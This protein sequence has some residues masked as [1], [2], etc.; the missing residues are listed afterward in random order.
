MAE[1]AKEAPAKK[2]G[3]LPLILILALVLGGGGFFGMKMR[4]G[5]S[6]KPKGPE[7]AA[8]I[9]VLPEIVAD[10]SDGAYVRTEVGVQL[11]KAFDPKKFEAAMPLV[12]QAANDT[13]RF[14]TRRDVRTLEGMR[15]LRREVAAAMNKA[16][17]AGEDEHGKDEKGKEDKEGKK[18]EKE[19]PAAIP[20]G[21]DSAEGPVLRIVFQSF[22]TQ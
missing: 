11:D 13:L 2:K 9:V 17:A 3:K 16:L 10:M 7:L 15:R 8:T 5:G 19:K 4:G 6:E 14:K 18:S 1:E 12:R 20:E 22:A 21:W